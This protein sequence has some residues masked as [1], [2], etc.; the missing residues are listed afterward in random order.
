MREPILVVLLAVGLGACGDKDDTGPTVVDSPEDSPRPDSPRDSTPGDTGPVDADGDGWP[1]HADCDDADPAV[2]PDATEICNG[3]DD[4]CD[5]LVDQVEETVFGGWASPQKAQE[6][7]KAPAMADLDGDGLDDL[8]A[9]VGG[10]LGWWLGTGERWVRGDALT[11]EMHEEGAGLESCAY[12]LPVDVDVDGAL[13]VLVATQGG[14]SL[15]GRLEWFQ[16]DGA[17]GLARPVEIGRSEAWARTLD[18]GDLDGDGLPEVASQNRLWWNEGGGVFTEADPPCVGGSIYGLPTLLDDGRS[19]VACGGSVWVADGERGFLSMGAI[20]PNCDSPAA[21]AGVRSTADFDGDGHLDLISAWHSL[22]YCLGDGAGNLIYGGAVF[23]L[24]DS[25]D[26]VV[27]ELRDADGDGWVDF[28]MGDQ[29]SEDGDLQLWRGDGSGFVLD[30]RVWLSSDRQDQE[31]ASFWFH[32]LDDGTT[33]LLTLGGGG[34]G[35]AGGLFDYRADAAGEM[36]G[37]DV[38]EVGGLDGLNRATLPADLDGDGHTDLVVLAENEIT[39]LRNAGDGVL[40][41]WTEASSIEG[42][43]HNCHGL[44]APTDLDGDGRQEAVCGQLGEHLYALRLSLSGSSIERVGFPLADVPAGYSYS[45]LLAADL[46]GDGDDELVAGPWVWSCSQQLGGI[47]SVLDV[48]PVSG[49]GSWTDLSADLDVDSILALAAVGDVTGDGAA[50][51]AALTAEGV[52]V[53]RWDGSAFLELTLSTLPWYGA[54]EELDVRKNM[55]VL[56][57]NGDGALDLVVAVESAGS[58][59]PLLGDGLGGFSLGVPL[60]APEALFE[61][62]CF[63][64]AEGVYP[65][66]LDATGQGRM[67]AVAYGNPLTA[68]SIQPYRET[69]AGGLETMDV[70]CAYADDQRLSMIDLDGDG[71][72]DLTGAEGERVFTYAGLTEPVTVDLCE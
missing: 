31:S 52:T 56:D 21:V 12:L 63:V 11:M 23:D 60:E 71:V 48:D 59:Q 2:N 70:V 7:L 42:P 4:D 46:D 34:G 54:G 58:L 20:S 30:Q 38:F 51:L 69:S 29:N 1:A 37:P 62:A 6:G 24:S 18:A 8:I 22:H 57:L 72:L 67:V 55:G 26:K 15:A 68:C 61:P 32:S 25:G 35:T 36:L 14:D 27:S 13:D 16:G 40:E 19:A 3:V 43:F 28:A 33:A 65:R 5:G 47:L 41:A 45:D 49:S 66:I 50:E 53:L 44:A 39:A 10:G 64:G 17:G 9:C